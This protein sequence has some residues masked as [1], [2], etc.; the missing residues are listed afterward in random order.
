MKIIVITTAILISFVQSS[1]GQ[2]SVDWGKYINE[3][4]PNADFS[5]AEQSEQ[6]IVSRKI[7]LLILL[8]K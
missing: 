6:L 3:P 8:E 7:F 2:Y 1:I 4:V 5:L